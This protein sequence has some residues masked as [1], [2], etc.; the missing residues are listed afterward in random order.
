M[1][2]LTDLYKRIDTD[3]VE[4]V[5]TYNLIPGGTY[6]AYLYQIER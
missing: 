6:H 3:K 5:E 1:F 2:L 4:Y